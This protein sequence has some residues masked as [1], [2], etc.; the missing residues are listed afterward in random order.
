[1]FFR[2]ISSFSE[3][4]MALEEE[5]GT[6]DI[7]LHTEKCKKREKFEKKFIAKNRFPFLFSIGIVRPE[8][9]GTIDP[10]QQLNREKFKT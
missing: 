4:G 10:R 7:S 1:M 8:V 2:N 3:I 6:L 5:C 9:C